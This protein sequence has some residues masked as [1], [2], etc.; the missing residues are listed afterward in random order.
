MQL[1]NLKRSSLMPEPASRLHV[2]AIGN[3]IIYTHVLNREV[4]E[5]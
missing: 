1:R 3:H 5:F 4:E 2:V